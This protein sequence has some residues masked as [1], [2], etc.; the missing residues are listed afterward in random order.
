M[1]SGYPRWPLATTLSVI[2]VGFVGYL[3]YG[4]TDLMSDPSY[5]RWDRAH[6][7][8]HGY[9]LRQPDNLYLLR[10]GLLGYAQH[11]QGNLPPIQDAATVQRALM[12]YVHH[13]RLFHN[14]TTGHPFIPNAALSNRKYRSI[15]NGKSIIAFYDPEPPEGYPEVYFVTLS[16]HVDHVSLGRWP[17][18]RQALG[19]GQRLPLGT[20]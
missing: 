10:L 5:Y 12:P 8:A 4:A 6:H 13:V 16:G 17:L 3:L 9:R 15:I 14:I 20:S 11:H 1:R 2:A 18:V 7:L 19:I